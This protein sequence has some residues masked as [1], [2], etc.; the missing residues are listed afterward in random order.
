MMGLNLGQGLCIFIT[1]IK[2]A[3]TNSQFT[4]NSSR[5][6]QVSLKSFVIHNCPIIDTVQHMLKHAKKRIQS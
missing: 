5:I 3:Y 4:D 1:I 6:V 2:A